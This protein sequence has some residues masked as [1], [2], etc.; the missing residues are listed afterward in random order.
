MAGLSPYMNPW[1]WVFAV[2]GAPKPCMFPVISLTDGGSQCGRMAGSTS[3]IHSRNGS[4]AVL[5]PKLC[6]RGIPPIVSV[7]TVIEV[8]APDSTRSTALDQPRDSPFSSPIG[9]NRARTPVNI[10]MK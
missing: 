3:H 4:L 6:I 2:L 10:A 9:M 7:I 8:I 5:N 1:M